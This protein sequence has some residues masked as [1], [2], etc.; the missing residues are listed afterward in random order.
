MN[1]QRSYTALFTTL[2]TFA[3]SSFLRWSNQDKTSGVEAPQ[4]CAMPPN[5]AG[6][7]TE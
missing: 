1:L 2:V 3:S 5:T 7:W 6:L 4:L